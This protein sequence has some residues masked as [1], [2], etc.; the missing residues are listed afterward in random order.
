[1]DNLINFFFTESATITL[2]LDSVIKFMVFVMMFSS[3]ELI[4]CSLGKVRDK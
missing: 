1:M 2:S 4:A 3:F